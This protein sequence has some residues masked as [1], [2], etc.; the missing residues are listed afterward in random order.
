MRDALAD[1]IDKTLGGHLGDTYAKPQGRIT[2][3]P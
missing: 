2:I 3:L 1:Y